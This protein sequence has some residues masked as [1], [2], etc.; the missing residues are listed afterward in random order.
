MISYEDGVHTGSFCGFYTPPVQSRSTFACQGRIGPV[1]RPGCVR[2]HD[3]GRDA[4]RIPSYKRTPILP[5]AAPASIRHAAARPTALADRNRLW[6]H[7][8]ERAA[9]F[10]LA[11]HE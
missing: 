10:T 11:S 3:R 8:G 2:H 1:T 5:F 9:N 4:G 6:Q 7:I